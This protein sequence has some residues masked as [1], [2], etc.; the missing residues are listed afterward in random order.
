MHSSSQTLSVALMLRL[1]MLISLS[2][3]T[4]RVICHSG[5]GFFAGHASSCSLPPLWLRESK[6]PA[7]LT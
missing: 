7:A 4:L 6:S 3:R 2:L 1:D 5:I